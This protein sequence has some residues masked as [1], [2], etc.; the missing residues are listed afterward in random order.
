MGIITVTL[1]IGDYMDK[2]RQP[3]NARVVLFP[4]TATTG[5]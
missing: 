4:I 5:R 1:I 3:D 2:E